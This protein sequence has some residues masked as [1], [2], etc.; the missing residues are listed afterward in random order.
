MLDV[1]LAV[2]C[3]ASMSLSATSI[4][5]KEEPCAV[6]SARRK[7]TANNYLLNEADYAIAFTSPA[8]V[9]IGSRKAFQNDLRMSESF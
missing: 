4:T 8:S 5:L 1:L 9:L 7:R 6:M 3:L 2:V